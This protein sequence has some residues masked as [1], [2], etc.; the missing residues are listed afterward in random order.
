MS[1]LILTE[2]LRATLALTAAIVLVLLLRRP[3]R[4][5]FGPTAAYL[6]WL[7]APLCLL[8]ALIPAGTGP[9]VLAPMMTVVADAARSLPPV[10]QR[11]GNEAPLILAVW[12]GGALV[13][14]GLFAARQLRFVG[15]LG[16][17]SPAGGNVLRGEHRGAG[18]FV[19]GFLRPKIVTPADFEERLAEG[20]RRLVLAHEQ[21]HLERGDAA[22]NGLV[23]LV[24]CLAWFNPLVHLAAHRLRMDQEIACDAI[25]VARHPEARRLY[26]ETLLDTALVPWAAPFACSWPTAGA[27]PL[28]ERLT[29]LNRD[30]FSSHRRRLGAV[31]AGAVVLAGA[32][33][34][35]A[36]SP[37]APRVVGKPDWV[38]TPTAKDLVAWYPEAAE[39][40]KVTGMVVM[41]CRVKKDGYLRAC[42]VSKQDPAKYGF[43]EA[44]LKMSKSFRMKEIDGDGHSTAGAQVTIPI[45]FA[46]AD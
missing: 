25:V 41:N 42:K 27:R 7:A 6:L 20:A 31:L 10:V 22:A 26:A 14:A 9:R 16:R 44:A 2:L 17:L 24:Q 29:M 30:P 40:A 15:M 18:P 13:A 34:V 21:V 3:V 23:A 5:G 36:A 39:K 8:A 45:K 35:W 11:A 4:A 37:T 12:A 1:A 38:Q 43:G 32:G 19:L 46:L 28:K 33:A